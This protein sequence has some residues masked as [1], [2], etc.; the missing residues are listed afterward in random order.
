MDAIAHIRRTT[1]LMNM[2]ISNK[3]IADDLR[4]IGAFSRNSRKVGI[5]DDLASCVENA[6]FPVEELY[7]Q[8]GICGLA[9]QFHE[10]KGNA[11]YY[12]IESLVYGLSPEGIIKER[13]GA[14]FKSKQPG[15][16]GKWENRY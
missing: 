6:D 13:I 5:Y 10:I 8:E 14:N 1:I 15:Q 2:P 3:K 11:G 4:I 7:W 12:Y 16:N 9:K